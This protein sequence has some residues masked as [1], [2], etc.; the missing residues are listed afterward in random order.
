[1]RQRRRQILQSADAELND[2][3]LKALNDGGAFLTNLQK[4]REQNNLIDTIG[5]L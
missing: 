4:L 2:G 5:I 1:M 3:R